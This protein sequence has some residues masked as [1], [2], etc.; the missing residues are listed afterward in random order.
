MELEGSERG[1]AKT[2]GVTGLS[3]AIETKAA[4]REGAEETGVLEVKSERYGG[5]CMTQDRKRGIFHSCGSGL[6]GQ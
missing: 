5:S 4:A 2:M 1:G 6:G 3:T